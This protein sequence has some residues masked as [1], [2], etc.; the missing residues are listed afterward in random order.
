MFVTANLYNQR[1]EICKK[2][3]FVKETLR[4]IRCSKCGCFM[5]LKARL[6]MLECPAGK[7]GRVG[8]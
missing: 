7:W 3:E 4:Q 2:C 5:S 1:I 8:N 6:S